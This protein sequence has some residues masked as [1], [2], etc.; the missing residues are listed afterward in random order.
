MNYTDQEIIYAMFILK[1]NCFFFDERISFLGGATDRQF[2]DHTYLHYM[3]HFDDPACEHTKEEFEGWVH[4]WTHHW[5]FNER[6]T[7]GM[8]SA[9]NV[10]CARCGSSSGLCK[11]EIDAIDSWNTRTP[12]IDKEKLVEWINN[13]Q[14]DMM[15]LDNLVLKIELG[16]FDLC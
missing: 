11:S 8:R 12:A 4:A 3:N 14:Y 5:F 1:A 15:D 9:W 16:E 6:D 10:V 7:F 2:F 13:Y